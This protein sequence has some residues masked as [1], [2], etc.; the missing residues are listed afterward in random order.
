MIK[1][2][3]TRAV[4]LLCTVKE[5]SPKSKLFQPNATFAQE[6]HNRPTNP[7]FITM[8]RRGGSIQQKDFQG[9]RSFSK[10]GKLACSN[11]RVIEKIILLA[12]A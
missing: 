1:A 7:L 5:E 10:W 2:A 12:T 11:L 4:P 3:R 8:G 9:S 6:K